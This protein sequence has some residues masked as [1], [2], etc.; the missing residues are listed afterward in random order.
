MANDTPQQTQTM[1]LT[2]AQM[3]GVGLVNWIGAGAALELALNICTTVAGIQ[4][5]GIATPAQ[6]LEAEH[7]RTISMQAMQALRRLHQAPGALIR[8]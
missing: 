2:P 8:S 7:L 3:T 5:P 1:T 6:V 4:V